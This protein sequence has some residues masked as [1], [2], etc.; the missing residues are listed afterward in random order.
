M[1]RSK[2]GEANVM[3][4]HP[5]KFVREVKA[6]KAKCPTKGATTILREMEQKGIR[7]SRSTV[8]QW[9]YGINR[10]SA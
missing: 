2:Y 3:C 5:D 6:I 7:L 10:A 9:L 8:N 4:R 1:S